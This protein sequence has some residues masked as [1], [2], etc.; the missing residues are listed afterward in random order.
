MSET[1]EIRFDRQRIEDL[2]SVDQLIGL[3]E[4][5]L[6]AMRDVLGQFVWDPETGTWKPSEVGVKLVGKLSIGRMAELSQDLDRRMRE[7]V[8]PFENGRA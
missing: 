2:I 7:A 4:G 8:V 1:I 5:D 6:R 3:Q